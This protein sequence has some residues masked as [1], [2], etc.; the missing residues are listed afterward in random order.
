MR[1][2]TIERAH[3]FNGMAGEIKY[4]GCREAC[5]VFGDRY[6]F[7]ALRFTVPLLLDHMPKNKFDKNRES[8]EP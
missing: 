7:D 4:T 5:S 2:R 8:V 6:D 3:P 1:R